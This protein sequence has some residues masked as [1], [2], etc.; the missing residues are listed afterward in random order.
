MMERELESFRALSATSGK[1]VSRAQ[2]AFQ[3]RQ[4]LVEGNKEN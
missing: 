1:P 3:E 2:R 4:A